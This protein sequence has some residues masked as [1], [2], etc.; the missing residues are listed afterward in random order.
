MYTRHAVIDTVLGEV[1]L[2]A[3]GM[4]IVGLY[5]R[6]HWYRPTEG[7]LGSGVPITSDELLSDAGRQLQEYLDGDRVAFDLPTATAGDSFQQAVWELVRQIPRGQTVT[8]G[9]LA[10]RLGDKT[11]AQSV[12]QAVGRNPLCV[13]LPCHR[14][15]GANGRLA[16]YAGGLARKKFLLDL[17]EPA[18]AKAE[19]LF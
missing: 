18:S 7:T 15:V 8:Y 4:S 10:D 17:E 12:G 6:H 9:D 11:L 16:G 2:V 19:R 3:S 13:I 5:F 14:V 1:T